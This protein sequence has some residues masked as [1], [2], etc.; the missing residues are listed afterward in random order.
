MKV[1]SSFILILLAIGLFYIF[2]SGQ[3]QEVKTLQALA[4]QYTNVLQNVSAITALRD[5]LSV[6]Y[7]NFSPTEIEQVGKVLPDGI[8]TVRLALDLD[9]MASKYG[10][11]IKSVKVN[12]SVNKDASLIVLP[13]ETSQTYNRAI[14]FVS[15]VARYQD[16]KYFLAD[17]ESSLRIMNVQSVSFQPTDSGLYEYQLAIETYWLK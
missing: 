10:I 11:A 2:T 3:Y 14:I 6:T 1:N 12:E 4:N 9:A 5:N 7:S 16:F 8:D 13:E 15:F 17:I